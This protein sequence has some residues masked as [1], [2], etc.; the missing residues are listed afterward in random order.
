MLHIL[1]HILLFIIA[2]L[3]EDPFIW[4]NMVIDLFY[5]HLNHFNFFS[6]TRFINETILI[7]LFQVSTYY[8]KNPFS[9]ALLNMFCCNSFTIYILI[10]S[11]DA[12][13]YVYHIEFLVIIVD[14]L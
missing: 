12:I 5:T 4:E 10:W 11:F 14:F 13:P 6:F 8:L 1:V 7:L 3:R 2:S 9:V